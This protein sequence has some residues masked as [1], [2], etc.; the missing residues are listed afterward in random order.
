[1]PA[2]VGET[3]TDFASAAP[4]RSPVEARGLQRRQGRSIS[5][6]ARRGTGGLGVLVLAVVVGGGAAIGLWALVRPK[7]ALR[8]HSLDA[9]APRIAQSPAAPPTEPPA[10][11]E[12]DAAPIPKTVA[13]ETPKTGA[14]RSH[15]SRKRPA[16]TTVPVPTG[17][18]YLSVFV[19]PWAMVNVDGKPIQQSPVLNLPLPAGHHVIDLVR[20]D[21]Q[22]PHHKRVSATIT[23]G[24]HLEVREA[25]E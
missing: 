14:H 2:P 19:R 8:D 6:P 11:H 25:L 20:T 10:A 1:M 13:V 24:G 5:A 7:A 12:V 15:G 21:H 3:K 22:P 4:P 17:E 18:G 23:A 16:E 9:A